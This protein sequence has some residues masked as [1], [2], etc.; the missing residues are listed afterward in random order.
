MDSYFDDDKLKQ[1]LFYTIR[2]NRYLRKKELYEYLY[3]CI[4]EGFEYRELLNLAE[5]WDREHGHIFSIFVEEMV[6][7]VWSHPR[8]QNKMTKR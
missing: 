7:H 5:V 1:E 8:K 3:K 2:R 6:G 4:D